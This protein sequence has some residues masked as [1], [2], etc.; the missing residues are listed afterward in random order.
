MVVVQA[1]RP[2]SPS[3]VRRIVSSG[4]TADN[5]I[6][7]RYVSVVLVCKQQDL[8][9][10]GFDCV[11]PVW[12][13]QMQ[14]AVIRF[15]SL[16]LYRSVRCLLSRGV[17]FCRRRSRTARGPRLNPHFILL[18]MANDKPSSSLDKPCSARFSIFV[19][20]SNVRIQS[21]SVFAE[22]GRFY[23]KRKPTLFRRQ[24]FKIVLRLWA[25]KYKIVNVR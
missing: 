4:T 21:P 9:L 7:P 22:W 10:F 2:S 17:S 19:G 1:S 5:P 18:L 14:N 25:G 24:T 6:D 3:T 23:K 15:L 13:E 11:F 12:V 16:Y 8:E 20:L